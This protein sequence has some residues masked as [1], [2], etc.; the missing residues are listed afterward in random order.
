MILI[1]SDAAVYIMYKKVHAGNKQRFWQ[2]ISPEGPV[3]MESD[4]TGLS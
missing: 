3:P 2:V 1:L 4:T